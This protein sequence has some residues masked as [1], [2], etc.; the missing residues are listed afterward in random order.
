MRFVRRTTVN[1]RDPRDYRLYVAQ[2]SDIIMGGRASL[3]LPKG[4]TG[5]RSALVSNGL[6]RY[7][8][9]TD[10]VEVYQSGTWRALRFKESNG[11]SKQT[12]TGDGASTYYGI[13]SP[14]P[15]AGSSN[16]TWNATQ[17]ALQ[18]IVL[19]E[20]VMQI[21]GSNYF[22]AQDPVLDDSNIIVPALTTTGTNLLGTT[23]I[24]VTPTNNASAN[25]T[26][27]IP[28]IKAGC[29]VT[30]T[31][32]G[33]PVFTANTTVQTIGTNSFTVNNPTLL[34]MPSGTKIT[35]TLQSGYYIRFDAAS[36]L[37]KPITI[38]SGFDK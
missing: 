22:I 10:E 1:P 5:D 18:F 4:E 12:F 16:T 36:V 29:V 19:V 26:D 7:N 9:T 34:A 14:A 37:N 6:V 33:S 25:F 38:L 30:A 3:Q 15:A 35:L 8:T 2:T 20:N 17:Y 21:G 23:T 27:V 24:I 13:L 31:V 11:I 32:L 28:N